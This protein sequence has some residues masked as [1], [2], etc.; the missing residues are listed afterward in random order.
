MN[1]DLEKSVSETTINNSRAKTILEYRKKGIR[2]FSGSWGHQIYLRKKGLTDEI[3]QSLEECVKDARDLNCCPIRERRDFQDRFVVEDELVDEVI[4]KVTAFARAIRDN[5]M[6]SAMLYQYQI[7]GMKSIV[8]TWQERID[9]A[10]ESGEFTS[11]DKTAVDTHLLH[12][13]SERADVRLRIDDPYAE[14][15]YHED[16][17]PEA[18]DLAKHFTHHVKRG[19]IGGALQCLHAIQNLDRVEINWEDRIEEA[20]MR[21]EF[22]DQDIGDA[23]S[24]TFNIMSDRPE[25]KE[26]AC[27][28]HGDIT[29]EAKEK[30]DLFAKYVREHNFDMAESLRKEVLTMKT[31]HP[32]E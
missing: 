11:Y 14:Y 1:V 7:I 26:M 24:T 22:T 23:N 31:I 5:D 18:L 17:T 9:K 28:Y 29:K 3:Y 21:G 32:L 20:K 2:G 30:R 19:E 4:D 12:P 15:D 25:V 27:R 8:L 13:M 10:L 6:D 16:F